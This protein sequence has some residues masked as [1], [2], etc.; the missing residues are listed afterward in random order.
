MPGEASRNGSSVPERSYGPEI[1]A[2][3]VHHCVRVDEG[4]EFLVAWSTVKAVEGEKVVPGYIDRMLGRPVTDPH[5]D[6]IP[7]RDGIMAP[8]TGVRLDRAESGSELVVRRVSDRSP[9][10]L[11]DL[12]QL[13]IR[14]GARIELLSPLSGNEPLAVR[15]DGNEGRIDR[16]LAACV[17]VERI[18]PE[19]DREAA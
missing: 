17:F 19:S 15:I 11:R 12:T 8:H 16:E 2:E 1:G 4:R 10:A 9:K 13:G 18:E 3:A 7:T 14:L 6:P 5:G